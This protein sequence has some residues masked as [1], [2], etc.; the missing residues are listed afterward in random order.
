MSKGNLD[1]IYTLNMALLSEDDIGPPAPG[2]EDDEEIEMEEIGHFQISGD[3]VS[4]VDGDQEH[5]EELINSTFKRVGE[6]KGSVYI[7]RH[8]PV[9]NGEPNFA[10]IFLAYLEYFDYSWE[11]ES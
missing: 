3:T 7:D 1:G 9:K 10:Q 4:A 5:L 6:K 11:K 8:V 2:E